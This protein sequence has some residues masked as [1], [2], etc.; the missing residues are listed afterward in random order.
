MIVVPECLRVRKEGVVG[1]VVGSSPRDPNIWW[2]SHDSEDP[3]NETIGA[4]W[5][6]EL[7]K[8]EEPDLQPDTPNPNPV[9]ER[10]IWD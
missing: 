9:P 4:Y 6:H 2:V 3:E 8:L 10:N 7:E 5:F 1:T